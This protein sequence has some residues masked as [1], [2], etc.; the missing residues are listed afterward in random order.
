MSS[1]KALT[2]ASTSGLPS[3]TMMFCGTLKKLSG[4]NR[5]PGTLF[6]SVVRRWRLAPSA[7]ISRLASALTMTAGSLSSSTGVACLSTR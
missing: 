3:G 5:E 6:I 4:S 2:A 7:S 1:M